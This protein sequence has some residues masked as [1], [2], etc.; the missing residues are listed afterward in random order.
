[1]RAAEYEV[2]VGAHSE[3]SVS[4]FQRKSTR[5]RETGMEARA[6]GIGAEPSQARL[7]HRALEWPR[8]R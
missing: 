8:K 5:Q 3:P 4:D 2:L 6:N 1:M 7:M